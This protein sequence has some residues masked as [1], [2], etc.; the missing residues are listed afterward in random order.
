M[1]RSRM[2]MAVALIGLGLAACQGVVE[3]HGGKIWAKSEPGK[4]SLFA[5]TLPAQR[6]INQA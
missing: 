4:G 3:A 6:K 1:N 5:F 2:W